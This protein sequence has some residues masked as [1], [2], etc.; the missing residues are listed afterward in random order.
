MQSNAAIL[1][2]IAE[3]KPRKVILFAVWTN[4]KDYG[5]GDGKNGALGATL[6]ELKKNVRDVVVIGQAPYWS[7]NLPT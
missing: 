1:Q 6:T 5:Q 3:L 4:Y 2:K 7:P